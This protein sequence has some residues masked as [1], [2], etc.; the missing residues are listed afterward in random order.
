M[1]NNT[2]KEYLK[3]IRKRYPNATIEGKTMILDEFYSNCG[4]KCKY[5]IR[6]INAK[7]KLKTIWK[8]PGRKRRYDDPQI[9]NFLK[10]LWVATNL[11]YLFQ[12]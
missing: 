5:A 8:K 3:K 10:K 11:M 7:E 4:Y 12:M 2:R 6:V 1:S 9:F